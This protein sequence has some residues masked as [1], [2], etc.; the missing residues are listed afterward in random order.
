MNDAR[1]VV[2]VSN[3]ASAGSSIISTG[4]DAIVARSFQSTLVAPSCNAV[5]W[6]VAAAVDD[7]LKMVEI[8]FTVTEGEVYVYAS[9]AGFSGADGYTTD[10]LTDSI[11]NDAFDLRTTVEVMGDYSGSGY[12]VANLQYE[13]QSPMDSSQSTIQSV[14]LSMHTMKLSSSLKS[15][16]HPYSSSAESSFAAEDLPNPISRSLNSDAESSVEGTVSCYQCHD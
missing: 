6:I 4:G 12:G 13:I 8:I 16:V 7:Y 1:L 15:S 5:A 9:A 2:V 3:S 10:T 11:V 14:Q